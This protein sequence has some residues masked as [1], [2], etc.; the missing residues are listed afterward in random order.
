MTSIEFLIFSLILSLVIVYLD[1]EIE[2]LF[3]DS[4]FSKIDESTDDLILHIGSL[5]KICI[6]RHI[7][8]VDLSMNFS[9]LP[10]QML[11]FTVI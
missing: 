9:F 8:R 5:T 1:R 4:D 7:A 6:K 2:G 3:P 10:L 11:N